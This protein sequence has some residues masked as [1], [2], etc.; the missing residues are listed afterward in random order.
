MVCI[1]SQGAF[2]YRAITV[3]SATTRANAESGLDIDVLM[4]QAAGHV[5]TNYS[6]ATVRIPHAGFHLYIW[7]K[8]GR[9]YYWQGG[10]FQVLQS[11]D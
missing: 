1:L 9:L 6:S 5:D 7:G 3:D 2:G 10:R 8:A 11:S 4:Y